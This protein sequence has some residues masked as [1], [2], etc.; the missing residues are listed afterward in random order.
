[1]K[2]VCA[3][4]AAD[5]FERVSAAGGVLCLA[6][7]PGRIEL[8]DEICLVLCKFGQQAAVR[9][10]ISAQARDAGFGID[11]GQDQAAVSIGLLTDFQ[12]FRQGAVAVRNPFE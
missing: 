9:S 1:M 5:A 11:A 12:D 7:F 3:D 4:V 10:E 8:S 6:I 2:I